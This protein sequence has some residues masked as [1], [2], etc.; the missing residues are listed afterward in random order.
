MGYFLE[1][2]FGAAFMSGM[3]TVI[4]TLLFVDVFDTN[5]TLTSVANVAGRSR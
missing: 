5:S 4:F 1:F 2:D 3:S